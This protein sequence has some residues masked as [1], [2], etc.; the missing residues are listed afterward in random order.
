MNHFGRRLYYTGRLFVG[1]CSNQRAFSTYPQC[2]ALEL[3][4]PRVQVQAVKRLQ[5][6]ALC[7]A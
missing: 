4:I 3:D 6:T 5:Y 7:S 1:D 2:H